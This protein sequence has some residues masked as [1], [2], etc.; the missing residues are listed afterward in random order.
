MF[1]SE[2]NIENRKR[3]N[4]A[5]EG[6]KKAPWNKNKNTNKYFLHKKRNFK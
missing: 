3:C 2:K 6:K 1:D 4:K 5:L